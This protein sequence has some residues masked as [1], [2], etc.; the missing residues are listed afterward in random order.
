MTILN[1]AFDHGRALFVSDELGI[2]EHADCIKADRHI[3]RCQCVTGV[4]SKV[5][6]LPHLRLLAGFFGESCI[7]DQALLQLVSR[8]P[9]RW[10]IDDVLGELACSMRLW[11]ERFQ[12][13]GPNLAI[14]VHVAADRLRAWSLESPGYAAVELTPGLYALPAVELNV[15]AQDWPAIE[16]A[17]T[18]A[19]A[20]Q[21]AL[22]GYCSGGHLHRS[23]LSRDGFQIDWSPSPI[24]RNIGG[25]A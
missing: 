6:A 5:A 16:Q 8:T 21:N 20:L 15:P 3:P 18:E 4:R 14:I 7:A 11:H 13:D 23:R 12:S 10:R 25:D 2:A 1:L 24:N 9:E 19:V 17:M 22:A